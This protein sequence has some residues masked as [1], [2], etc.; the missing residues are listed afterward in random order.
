M[1]RKKYVKENILLS[2]SCLIAIVFVFYLMLHQCVQHYTTNTQT[3]QI[4]QHTL[5]SDEQA[6]FNDSH[7]KKALDA[8]KLNSADLYTNNDAF[9]NH[10]ALSAALSNCVKQAGFFIT[11]ITPNTKDNHFYL[12]I[13]ATGNYFSLFQLFNKL[14]TLSWPVVIHEIHIENQTSYQ[15]NFVI[16]ESPEDASIE[17]IPPS[18]PPVLLPTRDPFQAA[19]FLPTTNIQTIPLKNHWIP[20]YFSKASDVAAFLSKKPSLIL[21]SRGEID[22]DEHSNQLWIKDDDQHMAAIRA[23]IAHL[24][25]PAQQFLI[26][27]KIINLDRDYQKNLGFLFQTETKRQSPFTQLSVDKPDADQNAGEFTVS[28]AKLSDNHILD[29]Q[30][31]ALE[32]EGHASLISNPSLTTLNNEA[33]VIESGSEVPYQ[34]ATLSGGTSVSFKKAVLRLKVIPQKMPHNRILLHISLNQDKVSALTV[35]GV[36]AIQTQQITT[37]VVVKNNQTIVLGG[38]LETENATQAA[39]TPVL[40]DI[41]IMGKLFQHNSLTRNQRELL[42]FITPAMMQV[43]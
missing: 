15:F 18:E 2:V 4:V 27:A 20:L 9:S 5:L 30:I 26:R 36:P 34:E 13:T 33:A 12:R 6:Q 43:F 11:S 1:F 14:N 17:A 35:K 10:D 21:S 3:I 38:I 24:D 41:P 19:L 31:S 23:L 37:Q 29:M 8:I 42:I 7:I 16:L 22:V 32:E 40:K 25:Q 39:G 28:I